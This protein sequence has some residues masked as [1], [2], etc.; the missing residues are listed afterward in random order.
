MDYASNT[1]LSIDVPDSIGPYRILGR[2]AEGGMGVVYKAEQQYPIIRTVAVKVIKL[3][4][5]TLEVVARFEAERQALGLMSHPNIAGVFDAGCTAEGRPYFAMEYVPGEPITAY[6]DRNMLTTRQRLA[7]FI[8]A[9]DAVQH[10]HLKGVIHRDIKPNNILVTITDGK[11]QVKVI[12][13]GI[14]KALA[15]RLKE[16]TLF[17][18]HGRLLGTPGYVSPEQL[19]RGSLDVD[20]RADVYGLGILLY[21]MLVGVLPFEPALL[22]AAT[23]IR[24]V[25]ETEPP[26]PSARFGALEGGDRDRISESRT[27][28][29]KALL[30]DLRKELEL[31][32]LKAMR[33]ERVERYQS[34]SDLA[35]DVRNYLEGRALH[36]GPRS[37]TYLVRKFIHNHST[38]VSMASVAALVI[39]GLI[40]GL[41]LVT[42][43]AL[44]A[45]GA[46]SNERDKAN[47]EAGRAVRAQRDAEQLLSDRL[48]LFGDSMAAAGKSAEARE[49][50]LQ[51]W[52]T[53]RGLQIDD[54]PILA[55]LFA[56]GRN[57]IPLMGSYQ[58]SAGVGGFSA[59]GHPN[60]LALFH[61]G[62][63][64]VTCDNTPVI[65]FWDLRTGR[66]LRD[67]TT[68]HTHG[69]SYVS[70]SPDEK[71]L[72]SA[73]YDG[74]IEVWDLEKEVRR[75]K[76]KGQVESEVY[77]AIFAPDG[78]TIVSGDT[79]G[80]VIRWDL[81]NMGLI[82]EWHHNGKSGA[83]V[84]ALAFSRD[85]RILASGGHD[86]FIKL[87]DAESGN[88]LA[89][90]GPVHGAKKE[91]NS[92]AWGPDD[93]TIISG[94]FDGMVRQW[95]L[96]E[97]EKSREIGKHEAEVWRVTLSPDDKYVAS[98]SK[99][100]TVAL[101]DIANSRLKRK[102]SG[103][104]G[105]VVGL[106]FTGDGRFLVAGGE[107]S[108]LRVW[109][110]SETDRFAPVVG[111][112]SATCLALSNEDVALFGTSRGAVVLYDTDSGH[113]LGELNGHTGSVS[114][115][116]FGQGGAVALSGWREGVAL[117]DIA[118]GREIRRF[119]GDSGPVLD[120]RLVSEETVLV[121]SERGARIWDFVA[122]KVTEVEGGPVVCI[123]SCPQDHAYLTVSVD[124]TV[125]LRG[126]QK[127]NSWKLPV[128]FG[129]PRATA[130]APGGR[131]VV[132]IAAGK[133][134]ICEMDK[135]QIVA[136][137]TDIGEAT[138]LA[139]LPD[140]QTLWI[141]GTNG[142]AELWDV[143][144]TK[145]LARVVEVP[146]KIT[147]V[148]L[149]SDAHRGLSIDGPGAAHVWDFT[150]IAVQHDFE[151]RLPKARLALGRASGDP[152]AL[153]AFGD[154]FAFRGKADWAIDFLNKANTAGGAVSHLTLA[155]CYWREGQIVRAIQQ[156]DLAR[157]KGE[158]LPR[159]HDLCT[160]ALMSQG[161]LS[162]PPAQRPQV[163]V[164]GQ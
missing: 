105:E 50:F 8:Q 19:Q 36:A 114:A 109:E 37:R 60:C 132:V 22:N 52:N 89:S 62:T 87:W 143:Q 34:A 42:H 78:Q 124:G 47:A 94:G 5:D 15:V 75:G 88:Q 133:L 115:V 135:A 119:A 101:W 4:M 30:R 110:T 23:L 31:I 102:F 2:I 148:A 157:D 146:T 6:C 65:K 59:S 130:L 154:W 41:S 128:D 86:G 107:D 35:D 85:H 97:P 58:S 24:I 45:E 159:Y 84:A 121:R 163:P 120:L 106:A 18:E 116:C 9:C 131:T 53:E 156:F 100:G 117:W 44:K 46:L 150:A 142:V 125:R 80:N 63:T 123:A 162:A 108:S 21:E 17:T 139:F 153:A 160:R 14:A 122:D 158:I 68:G 152:E 74:T 98:G 3:G 38:A 138:G 151:S 104:T 13:F 134:C 12:D 127:D 90:I 33:T 155:R 149:A 145:S 129:Q 26:K 69:A 66:M 40:V 103:H 20:T 57:D 137:T 141:F 43:R 49:N 27:T 7:L 112:E 61:D 55:R 1:P 79:R 83:A 54:S 136:V 51:A 48:V 164:L 56:V 93:R 64:V 16:Q 29:W 126:T 91:I 28:S 72:L 140:G 113:L 39:L 96:N 81:N 73:G 161:D 10:A 147:A 71:L 77:V 118:T 25:C 70:I 76:L 92:L 111:V 67:F 82:G 32:P 95:D 11:P 144:H 99:D